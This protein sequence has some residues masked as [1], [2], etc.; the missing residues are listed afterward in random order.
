M[1]TE[2]KTYLEI[3]DCLRKVG[4]PIGLEFH[5]FLVGWYN[6]CVQSDAFHLSYERDTLAFCVISQPKFFERYFLPYVTERSE[7]M[8]TTL[9][10]FDKCFT[11]LFSSLRTT[12]APTTDVDVLHDFELD[13]R[14]RPKILVQTAGH[15]SGAAYYYQRKDVADDPWCEKKIFG[16]SCHPRFGGWFGFRGALIFKELQ[17]DT[18]I[19]IAPRDFLS[20]EQK[21]DFLHGFNFNWQNWTFRDIGNVSAQTYSQLQRKYFDKKPKERFEFLKAALKCLE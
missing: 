15:I 3:V 19:Q 10:P 9:D 5:P 11:K 20:R 18:L 6:D 16:A 14:R 17:Y 21:I 4:E 8:D 13:A 1:K 12:F 2:E 7:D